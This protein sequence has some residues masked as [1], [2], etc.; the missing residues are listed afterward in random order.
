MEIV[1]KKELDIRV[2]YKKLRKKDKGR[3]V[4]YL[5]KRF[6][7]NYATVMSKL[8]C[9]SKMT[10]LEIEAITNVINEELWKK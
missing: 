3:L 4:S 10:Q 9:R 8:N 2:Y 6:D 7:M 5:I 1:E